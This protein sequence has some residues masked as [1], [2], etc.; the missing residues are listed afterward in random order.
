[1]FLIAS[2]AFRHPFSYTVI[3]LETG[4]MRHYT[5][6]AGDGESQELC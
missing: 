1:M 2:A 6:Q 4:E 5:D 3:D